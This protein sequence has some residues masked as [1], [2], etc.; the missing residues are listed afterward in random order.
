MSPPPAI[1]RL[2]GAEAAARAREL[3]LLLIDC[4]LG[5][6]SV[7]F[8]APLSPERATAFWSKVAEGVAL[9]ERLLLVAEGPGREL[10]GTV[11]LVLATPENQPHRADL[12]KMLVARAARRQGVGTALLRAAEAEARA[13]GR[14]LLVLDTVTGSPADRLYSRAGWVRVGEI[15]GYA[16]WPEGGLCPTTFFYRDLRPG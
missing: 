13:A 3:A 1:R 10:L 12:A 15:P 6:A 8:M 5:G 4:V 16:L 14:W 9:G 2:D 11:Q 7:S